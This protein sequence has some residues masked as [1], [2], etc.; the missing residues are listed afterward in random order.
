MA[1]PP[2]LTTLRREDREGYNAI[3]DI[4]LKEQR[5]KFI[6]VSPSLSLLLYIFYVK[7]S[8]SSV[9]KHV[10]YHSL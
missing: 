10:M 6:V 8:T 2:Q 1:N 5:A 9:V 4:E 7:A 3:S